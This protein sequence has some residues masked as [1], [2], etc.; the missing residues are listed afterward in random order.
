MI[1]VIFNI[2]GHVI[3]VANNPK[4]AIDI[5]LERHAFRDDYVYNLTTLGQLDYLESQDRIKIFQLNE[6]YYQ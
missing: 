3:G 5:Y 1:Y 2:N 4:K 6:F